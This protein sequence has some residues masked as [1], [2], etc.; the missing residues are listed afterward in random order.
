MLELAAIYHHCQPNIQGLQV[1]KEMS[2][3]LVHQRQHPV[4]LNI[5]SKQ[6][7]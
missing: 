2:Q 4:K 6:G 7:V 5:E 1:S 3:S